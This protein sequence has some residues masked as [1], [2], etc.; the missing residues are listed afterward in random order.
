MKSRMGD[1]YPVRKVEYVDEYAINL[2]HLVNEQKEIPREVIYD[3]LFFKKTSRWAYEYEY[4]MV[5][6]LSDH[7][8]YQPPKTNIPY[9]DTNIYLFPFAWDCVSSVILGANMSMENKRL[10]ADRCKE[11]NIH[12]SQAFI[13]RDHRDWFDKPSTMYLMS[14]DQLKSEEAILRARA[15]TFCTDA[16]GLG[17]HGVIKINK[18]ANLPYYKD[19]EEIVEQLY[20]ALKSM[21]S[22]D[23]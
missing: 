5:R 14:F 11:H 22:G 21:R 16:I 20:S 3:E 4:R 13:I 8:D 6:P 15:E 12:L 10:I 1:G 17:N 18:I 23:R 9:T 7:P 19:Y 2:D